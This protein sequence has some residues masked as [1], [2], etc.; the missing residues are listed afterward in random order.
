MALGLATSPGWGQAADDSALV[1]PAPPTAQEPTD[2]DG[3]PLG[4]EHLAD[5]VA[6]LAPALSPPADGPAPDRGELLARLDALG[7]DVAPAVVAV[8]CGAARLPEEGVHPQALH[9]RREVLQDYAA[10]RPSAE[11]IEH[12][13]ELGDATR[14]ASVQ[15]STLRFLA[16][17]EGADAFDALLRM[18]GELDPLV[19]ASPS[20][21]VIVSASVTRTFDGEDAP[22]SLSTERLPPAL[23]VP[24]AEGVARSRRADVIPLLAS[25]LGRGPE[26][27]RAVLVHIES[28]ARERGAAADAWSRQ[29]VRDFL[30]SLHPELR[31]AAAAAACTLRDVEAVDRVTELL[32]DA[33]PQVVQAA[34]A[35]LRSLAGVDLG[36]EREPWRDW[37]QAERAWFQEAWPDALRAIADEDPS[38]ARAAL[39]SVLEHPLWRDLTS[40]EIAPRLSRLEPGVA[41]LACGVLARL[42]AHGALPWIVELLRVEDPALRTSA[43]EALRTL[44]G[45]SLPPD[46][47]AWAEALPRS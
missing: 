39:R 19:L 32:A 20:T 30:G 26:G 6:L 7:P 18:A 36:L 2:A 38:A 29:S 24:I 27:N 15:R 22:S 47:E 16:A 37:M 25:L 41:A 5:R 11:L 12:A 45:L 35:G 33:H 8:L 40:E 4:A 10:R 42:G 46:A 43:A 14:N 17:L 9:L 31:R 34:R 3:T 23:V 44:T 1:D 13:L 21:A 28:C